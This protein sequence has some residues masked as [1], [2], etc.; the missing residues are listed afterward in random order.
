MIFTDNFMRWTHLQLLATKDGIFKAYKSF[1]AW[2]RLHLEI[3][4]FKYLRSD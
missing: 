3:Q 1:Q 2:A 4:A